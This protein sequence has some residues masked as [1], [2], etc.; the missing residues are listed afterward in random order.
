M[1]YHKIFGAATVA[2]LCEAC[3]AKPARRYTDRHQSKKFL[4]ADWLN[5]KRPF[6]PGFV[7]VNQLGGPPDAQESNFGACVANYVCPLSRLWSHLWFQDRPTS[8]LEITRIGIGA[9]L[10]LHYALA[11][12]TSLRSGA[13]TAGCRARWQCT[14]DPLLGRNRSSSILPRPGSGSPFTLSF[15]VLLRRLHAGVADVL[16]EMDR[17]GRPNL[18]STP[19]PEH[20]LRRRPGSFLPAVDFMLRADRPR[21]MTLI[22]CARFALAKR[23]ISRPIHRLHQSLGGACTRLMQIQM[24]VLFFFSA[25]DKLGRRDGGTGD[26]V[27]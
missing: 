19:R 14:G 16:G 8:P 10:S 17:A 9:A 15:L 23:R 3:G 5:G 22:G 4:S 2:S 6:D 27:W 1:G 11:S 12:P 25:T 18:L 24:A 21:A 13:T 7:D 20:E 26:A